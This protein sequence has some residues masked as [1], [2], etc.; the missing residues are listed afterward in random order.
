MV[1]SNA[2]YEAAGEHGD[3]CGGRTKATNWGDE[4]RWQTKTTRNIALKRREKNTNDS[5]DD[6]LSIWIVAH[7]LMEPTTRETHLSWPFI[8]LC[9]ISF[10]NNNNNKLQHAPFKTWVDTKGINQSQCFGENIM[11]ERN[12]SQ[13]ID[14]HVISCWWPAEHVTQTVP[15]KTGNHSAKT[16]SHRDEARRRWALKIISIHKGKFKFGS[17]IIHFFKIYLFKW[18]P[19]D[20][21]LI[22]SASV[23]VWIIVW[24]VKCACFYPR[25]V[26]PVYPFDVICITCS[27]KC[28]RVCVS[29][30]AFT[31]AHVLN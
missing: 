27:S 31:C 11:T 4:P 3:Q 26:C 19:T 23:T 17:L 8:T 16:K 29:A 14:H 20:I 21:C 1:K 30:C 6:C 24:P 7:V 5:P 2:E 10:W 13:F 25:S 22:I 18:G 28:V 12:D 9:P 15:Y